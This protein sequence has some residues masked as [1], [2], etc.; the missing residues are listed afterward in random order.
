MVKN[1]KS[2]MDTYITA[3]DDTNLAW[4]YS[5]S[6]ENINKNRINN[7]YYNTKYNRAIYNSDYE[8]KAG[9]GEELDIQIKYRITIIN[10]SQSIET[11]IKEKLK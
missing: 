7:N 2:C 9:I 6:Q 5:T 3:K 10:T 8:A 1:I 4:I 11:Q